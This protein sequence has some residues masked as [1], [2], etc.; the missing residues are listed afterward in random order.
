MTI[1]N[2]HDINW[3]KENLQLVVDYYNAISD[4]MD[5][6]KTE[7][8]EWWESKQF[9]TISCRLSSY[10]KLV[11]VDMSKILERYPYESNQW[12]YTLSLTKDAQSVITDE[13]LFKEQEIKSVTFK[14][15]VVDVD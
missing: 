15:T 9:G 10:K 14:S 7:V 11:P 4:A 12:L 13:T 2:L 5:T 3:V 8:K 6:I 1:E